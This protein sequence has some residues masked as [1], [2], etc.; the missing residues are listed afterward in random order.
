VSWAEQRRLTASLG[1]AKALRTAQKGCATPTN[2]GGDSAT[3]DRAMGAR[4]ARAGWPHWPR[5]GRAGAG[6]AL[7]AHRAAGH[8]AARRCPGG[9]AGTGRRTTRVKLCAQRRV[10]GTTTGERARHDGQRKKRRE[11]EKEREREL[12]KGGWRRRGRVGR[13]ASRPGERRWLGKMLPDGGPT[14]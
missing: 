13:R 3:A 2:G 4:G 1:K 5:V 8:Q 9:L 12:G 14:S 11:W 6:R 10:E 7:A